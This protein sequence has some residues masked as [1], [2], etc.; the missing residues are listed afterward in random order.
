MDLVEVVDAL[1]A[2]AARGTPPALFLDF[3][4]TLVEL[5]AHPQAVR[6]TPELV[7]LLG[8]LAR[9]LGGALAIV[10]GRPI[11]EV[12][13]FLAPLRLPIAGVHGNEVRSVPDGAAAPR[14]A[15]ELGRVRERLAR[16][17]EAWPGVTV[18][19]KGMA[20]AVHYRA[21]PDAAPEVRRIA[22][23]LQGE[24]ADA[25]MLLAG[26]MV[27]ELVP[28]GRDKGSAIRELLRAAPFAG[29][30][31]VFLGDDVTDEA[32]FRA[33]N[34][35]RGVSVRVGGQDRPTAARYRVDNVV[36]VLQLLAA[37]DRAL[38]AVPVPGG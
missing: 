23:E 5:A 37:L 10:T 21:V 36:R 1:A 25:L 16:L 15:V 14:S 3:D 6:P 19:D 17:S 22:E 7:P 26:K 30:R 18:E 13:R 24:S 38:A 35:L 28:A 29:R 4:G 11:A 20:I 9:R 31:P 8:A 2:D 32:G 34:E 27:I 33:V 12:D